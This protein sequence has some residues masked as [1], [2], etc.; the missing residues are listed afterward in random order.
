MPSLNPAFTGAARING[1]WG[2]GVTAAN[3]SAI[4]YIHAQPRSSTP[5]RSVNHTRPISSATRRVPHLTTSTG[6]GNYD[7]DLGLNRSFP[8]HFTESARINLRADRYNITNHT[9]FAVASPVCGNANFGQVAPERQCTPQI[10]PT[11]GPHRF[12]TSTG[13]RIAA[14]VN[15]GAANFLAQAISL[16]VHQ[17]H[18]FIALR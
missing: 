9:W 13:L 18:C 7:L 3:Y 4:N 1:K 2:Q 17:S 11:L 5:R 12:L 16:C 15:Q 14:A 8:L 10:R 6:P